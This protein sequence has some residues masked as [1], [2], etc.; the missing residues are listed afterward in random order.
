MRDS[1]H[2][3]R[4]H[5]SGHASD[6]NTSTDAA[7]YGSR[8][9]RARLDDRITCNSSDTGG[10]A[11]TRHTGA[12]DGGRR[13]GGSDREA[14]RRCLHLGAISRLSQWDRFG[15]RLDRAKHLL[16]HRG[17]VQKRP[18]LRAGSGSEDI[19]RSGSCELDLEYRRSHNAGDMAD[20]RDL[21]QRSRAR[22]LRRPV[23][24]AA[25]SGPLPPR[26]RLSGHPAQDE[27]GGS[28]AS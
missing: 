19:G 28:R 24:R 3:R 12:R 16:Q 10:D 25:I 26:W 15:R 6:R 17:D 5:R 14:G 11:G 2:S 23:A 22:D 21:R 8:Y 9:G 20:R 1:R 18:E 4:R 27:A 13:D 7:R